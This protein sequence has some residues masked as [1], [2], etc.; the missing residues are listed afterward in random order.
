M[1]KNVILF[2]A[3][4]S[5]SVHIYNENKDILILCEGSTQGLDD[6]A[7]TAEKNAWVIKKIFIEFLTSIVSASNHTK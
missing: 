4:M 2:G 3:D 5:L 1:G 7:L 6:T